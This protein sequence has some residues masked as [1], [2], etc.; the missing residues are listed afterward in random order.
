MVKR[1][2]LSGT[3][4]RGTQIMMENH[5]TSPIKEK[6]QQKRDGLH[7]PL[8][9]LQQDNVSEP[10]HLPTSSEAS[11]RGVSEHLRFARGLRPEVSDTSRPT[12]PSLPCIRPRV[13][14]V[15]L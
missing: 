14:T 13:D 2:E 10:A 15:R 1:V 4:I 12:V 7:S 11:L 5:P 6:D 9:G 3:T 8:L